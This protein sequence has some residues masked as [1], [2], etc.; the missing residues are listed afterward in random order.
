MVDTWDYAESQADALELIQEAGCAVTF[1][2]MVNSGSEQEPTQTPLSP[3]PA[4]YAVRDKF[5]MRHYARGNVLATD[6]RW[7]VAASPLGA[8]VPTP[9]DRI[10]IGGTSY[11]IVIAEP[12]D[13]SAAVPVLYDVQVRV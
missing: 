4:S 10:V 12:L 6:Q 11:E 7:L 9:A 3:A 13:P 8:F 1:A 5:T 2:H